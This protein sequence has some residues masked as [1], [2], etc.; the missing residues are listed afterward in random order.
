MTYNADSALSDLDYSDILIENNLLF[1]IR[2]NYVLRFYLI[3]SNIVARNNAFAGPMRFDYDVSDTSNPK[4]HGQTVDSTLS[5]S[6]PALGFGV[7]ARPRS[8]AKAK[9]M[10]DIRLGA[11]PFG[12][13]V[14]VVYYLHGESFGG[15]VP[16]SGKRLGLGPA[17]RLRR[18]LCPYLLRGPTIMRKGA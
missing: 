10:R 2:N 5:S 13:R 16:S 4:G 6:S 17:Q 14:S 15:L 7:P 11:M 1:G 8:A 9:G 18:A 12:A 3:H